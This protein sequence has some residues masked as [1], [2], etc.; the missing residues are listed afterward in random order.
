MANK[1][2]SDNGVRQYEW[3]TFLP[4]P[5][6]APGS[7]IYAILNRNNGKIYIGSAVRMAHRWTCHRHDLS[8]QKH[9]SRYFQRAFNKEPQAFY[10]EVIEELPKA[11]KD[12]I[13]GREQFW[14]DFYK[15]YLPENGYN[16]CPKAHSCQGVKH[17]P[18]YSESIS[19]R[20]KGVKWTESRKERF[21]ALRK[22]TQKCGWHW[23]EKN[24]KILSE[25][26]KGLKWKPGQREKFLKSNRD[27]PLGFNQKQV[28]QLSE[29]GTPIAFF[30][31]IVD[32]EKLFGKRSNIHAVCKGKRHAAFGFKWRY[33]TP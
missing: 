12:T 29:E 25:A 27:N 22:L 30:K 5:F 33:K 14:I 2:T 28:E 20:L 1:V 10:I 23:S 18:E 32:A 6:H 11:N 7:G 17:G 3:H 16:I 13:I 19:L 4:Q 15:S 9:N 24:K 8:R 31:S 21:K 26:H